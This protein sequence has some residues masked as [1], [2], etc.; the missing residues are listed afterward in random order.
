MGKVSLSGMDFHA[1]H[2]VYPEEKVLGN[3]FTVDLAL[4]TNFREALLHD[5]LEDTVD[6]TRL[7]QLVKARMEQPVKLLEH[8]GYT[9]IQDIVSAYPDLE[10]VNVTIKK[11]HPALGGLTDFSSVTVSYPEDFA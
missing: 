10:Q 3:R 11:H 5:R 4:S 1:Y 9:I 6:Y 7:Y 8:L 2:G